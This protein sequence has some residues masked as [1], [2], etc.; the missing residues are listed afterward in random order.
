[1]EL[2]LRAGS[3][4]APGTKVKNFIRI[5]YKQFYFRLISNYL[6]VKKIDNIRKIIIILMREITNLK[7]ESKEDYPTI[8]REK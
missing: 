7:I 6:R 3:S 2:K 1:M 4:P 5:L 8:I